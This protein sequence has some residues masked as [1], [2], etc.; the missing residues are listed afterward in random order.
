MSDSKGAG[1]PPLRGE[2]KVPTSCRVTP[3]VKAYLDQCESASEE[4]ET[5]IRGSKCFREWRKSH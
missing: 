3:E 2:R 5:A 4:I 1:R